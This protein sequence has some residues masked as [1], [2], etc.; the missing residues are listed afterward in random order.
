[1]RTPFHFL[2]RL[3]EAKSAGTASL[4][5]PDAALLEL[6]AG[7]APTA[8]G[9]AVSV[10]TAMRHPAAACAIRIIAEAVATLPIITYRRDVD[11]SKERASDHPAY[12]LLH[13][14]AN[15]WTSAYDLKLA[16]TLDALT[17]DKG[18]IGFVNRVGG[19]VVEILRLDPAKVTVAYGE[20][21]EP[22]YRMAGGA[23]LPRDSILHIRAPGGVAPLTTA[24]EAIGLALVMEQ[25]GARLFGNGARPSG[26]LSLKERTQPE[27]IK[28]IRESWQLAHGGGRSGGTAIVDGDASYT[29]LT[30]TSVDAQYLE[31]RQFQIL[32]IA[33]AFRVPPHMLFELGRATWS[34]VGD[35]GQ[36][37]LT[38]SLLPWLEVWQGAIRRALFTPDERREYLA[39]F[40]VDD[41]LR[42]DLSSRADAY[43]KLIA[44]RVLNPNEARAMENRAPYA[45]GERFENPNTTSGAPAPASEGAA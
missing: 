15:D 44:S 22:A 26:V 32:E 40:L 43:Q 25:H 2:S 6:F 11:G 27:T 24:R 16:L 12:G 4:A 45:G 39:E 34:N 29:P 35:M 9:V 30:L 3:F 41:L 7:A 36:E 8:S 18:G 1:M 33:R 42:A 21:G 10:A 20:A 28:R 5:S 19:K 13:D 38:Y 14:D 23:L 17:T 37:F 31:L